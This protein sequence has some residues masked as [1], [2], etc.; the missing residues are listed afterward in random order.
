M[1]NDTQNLKLINPSTG[2]FD[3]DMAWWKNTEIL[4]CFPGVTTVSSAELPAEPWTGQLVF[5]WDD[6]ALLT[7]NGERWLDLTSGAFLRLEAGEEIFKGQLTA[8]SEE[9]LVVSAGEITPAIRILGVA[10]MAALPGEKVLLKTRG[11]VR[12]PEFQL[13]SG[14]MYYAGPE[15]ELTTS[16]LNEQEPVGIA[17]GIDVLLLKL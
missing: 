6:S 14:Q 4:D 17:L 11:K 2:E 7:W 5:L 3:W 13:E 12:L 16:P 10:V 8:L 1:K 9:G 15:G